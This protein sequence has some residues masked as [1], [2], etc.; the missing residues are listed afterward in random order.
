MATVERIAKKFV[1]WVFVS[2]GLIIL[3]TIMAIMLFVAVMATNDAIRTLDL[4]R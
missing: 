1:F 2:A 4:I 3:L